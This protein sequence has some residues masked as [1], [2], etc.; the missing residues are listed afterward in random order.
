MRKVGKTNGPQYIKL[1]EVGWSNRKHGQQ[2]RNTLATY[3]Y[4]IIGALPVNV[5]ETTHIEKVLTPIWSE[6][7]E[8][9][10]RVR[11]RIESVLDSAKV[12]GLREGENPARWK[13]HLK[14][15]MA[16]P[17]KVRKVKH[18]AA[19]RKLASRWIR[20]LFRVWKNRTAY[21]PAAYLA[22]IKRKN[23]A[24]VPFLSENASRGIKCKLPS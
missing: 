5:I 3:A 11:G 24:I 6:K 19:L 2:W 16:N 15:L 20:I 13:G 7:A 23:P 21:D 9:A 14:L 22:T 10:K 17:S 18:H 4:P 12:Q 1:N 8:T